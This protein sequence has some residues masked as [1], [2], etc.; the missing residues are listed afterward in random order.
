MTWRG[1]RE[2]EGRKEAEKW[3]ERG[4]SREGAGGAGREGGDQGRP[5]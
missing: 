4:G 1:V 5:R 3:R 2:G